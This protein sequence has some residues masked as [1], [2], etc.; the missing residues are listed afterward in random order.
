MVTDGILAGALGGGLPQ[1]SAGTAGGGERF[2]LA[3]D[4]A[5][6]RATAE[7]D[8]AASAGAPDGMASLLNPLMRLNGDSTRLAAHADQAAQT[9]LRPSELM[10]LTMR[11]HEFL[12]HCELVANVANRSSDGVQQLFRQQS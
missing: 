12:F 4:R 3:L 10:M 5:T 6:G 8:R 2:A 1:V 7:P 11:S 9:E